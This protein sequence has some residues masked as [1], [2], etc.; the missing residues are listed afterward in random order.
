MYALCMYIVCI[1][2]LMCIYVHVYNLYTVCVDSPSVDSP[3]LC[4]LYRSIQGGSGQQEPP[5][6]SASWEILPYP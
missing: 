2:V 3:S 4:L 5:P 1:C 6:P